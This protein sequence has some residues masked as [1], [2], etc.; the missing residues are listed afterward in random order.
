MRLN[1]AQELDKI[2]NVEMLNAEEFKRKYILIGYD[3]ENPY[4]CVIRKQDNLPG[5]M[6]YTNNPRLFH[7]F[8]TM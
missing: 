5:T 2:L 6:Q 3:N 8:E 7:S 4:L 1:I